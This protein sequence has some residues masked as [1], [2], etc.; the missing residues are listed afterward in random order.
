MSTNLVAINNTAHKNTKIK[1][2][3]TYE[4]GKNMH[5]CLVQIHEFIAASA[6]YPL[7]FIKDPETGEFRGVCMM[8]LVPG[9]NLYYGEE[10]WQADYVPNVIS[11]HPWGLA[12]SEK[13]PQEL[14]LSLDMSSAL[15]NEEEGSALFEEDGSDSK[16]LN[17][18]KSFIGNVH[19][20]TPVTIAF[21][22]HMAELELLAPKSLSVTLGEDA[23]PMNIE[24]IYAVDTEALEKL[25]DEA[26][27]ELRKRNY[28]PVIFAHLASLSQVGKL[29]RRK[30]KADGLAV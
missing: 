29:A 13:N 4:N 28:L 6:E 5:L 23:K 9:E 19:A 2:N 30:A 15:V 20:Q 26:F 3:P 10:A 12:P 16:Y 27:L 24:G 7:V 17:T 22:K 18:V 1:T 25:S 11:L 21:V 8:G 14:S